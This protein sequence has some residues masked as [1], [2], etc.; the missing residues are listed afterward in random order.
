MLQNANPGNVPRGGC[1]V[2]II[3]MS[4]LGALIYMGMKWAS[5]YGEEIAKSILTSV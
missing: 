5:E 3:C 2:W 1:L 4:I